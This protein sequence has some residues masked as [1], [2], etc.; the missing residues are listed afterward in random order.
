M[1]TPLSQTDTLQKFI[2]W[3]KTV[4]IDTAP[5]SIHPGIPPNR[6]EDPSIKNFQQNQNAS[7]HVNSDI[8]IYQ[9]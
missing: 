5:C 4:P 3:A 6:G 9:Q 2:D 7:Q 8:D 1:L